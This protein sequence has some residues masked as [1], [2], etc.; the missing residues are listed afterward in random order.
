M[1]PVILIGGVHHNILGVVRAFGEA[2]MSSSVLVVITDAAYDF[3]SRSKNRGGK[4]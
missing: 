3:V 2:D 1:K 4:F